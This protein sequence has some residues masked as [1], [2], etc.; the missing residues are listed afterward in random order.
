MARSFALDIKAF[1]EKAKDRADFVVKKVGI[2]IGSSLVMMTPVDTGHA[3]HNW[4]VGF[5]AAMRGERE[6]FDKGGGAT[7]GRIT[8]DVTDKARFGVTMYFN[9]NIPYGVKLEYGHSTQAPNGMVRVTVARFKQFVEAAA[10][11]AQ[12]EHP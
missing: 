1:A 10:K 6:G 4:N 3:R 7:V 8:Q 11:Q 5:G 9:L 12:S 2:D